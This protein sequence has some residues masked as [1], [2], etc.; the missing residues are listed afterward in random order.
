MTESETGPT[1]TPEDRLGVDP[2]AGAGGRVAGVADGH[3]AAQTGELA[4]VEHGGDQTH[5][6]HHGDGVAVA[7]GHA[8]RLLAAVLQ[9]VET[10]EGQVCHRAPRGIDPE[11]SASFLGLHHR[12]V[13]AHT[14]VVGLILD[15]DQA[16]QLPHRATTILVADAR[17]RA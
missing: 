16:T 10:V 7:H 3:V 13:T 1:H 2:V 11:D 5:V 17:G 8:G 14:G 6:L 12:L 15:H 4:L 9:G